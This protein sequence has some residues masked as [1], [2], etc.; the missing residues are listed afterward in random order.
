M[1]INE[2]FNEFFAE[3][4]LIAK[5]QFKD[6]KKNTIMTEEEFDSIWYDK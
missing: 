6:G 3:K 4:E 1:N 2:K 5:E